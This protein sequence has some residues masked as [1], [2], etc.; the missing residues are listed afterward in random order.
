MNLLGKVKCISCDLIGFIGYVELNIPIQLVVH[1][2]IA[3]KDTSN[4]GVVK[5]TFVIWFP[6]KRFSTL[7]CFPN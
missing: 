1:S 3:I 2:L 4:G 6:P 5:P 7:F